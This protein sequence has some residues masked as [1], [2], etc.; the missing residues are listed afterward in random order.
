MP[1]RI[2]NGLLHNDGHR[3]GV[4]PARDEG[5]GA[6]RRHRGRQGLQRS[7]HPTRDEGSRP[8]PGTADGHEPDLVRLDAV[9]GGRPG[10]RRMTSR[11]VVM[12]QLFPERS[13]KLSMP[14]RTTITSVPRSVVLAMIL[15]GAPL[16]YA[17]NA[18]SEP[19]LTMSPERP[20]RGGIRRVRPVRQGLGWGD[21]VIRAR[22]Q[23]R[24]TRSL[25]P[26]WL[27]WRTKPQR[28]WA[29]KSA[30]ESMYAYKA[31][32]DTRH[33]LAARARLP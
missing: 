20:H 32:G 27:G 10:R 23:R 33:L 4:H 21:A 28:S 11:G 16:S 15:I 22:E 8:V 3:G 25:Q 13:L 17:R 7:I 29:F 19:V 31:A 18:V 6:A 2:Q 14:L 26:A 5:S 1:D 9:S 24:T 30:C 12:A